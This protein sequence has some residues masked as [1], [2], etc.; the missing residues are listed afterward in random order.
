MSPNVIVPYTQNYAFSETPN[1]SDT[2][3]AVYLH[4]MEDSTFT[5]LTPRFVC[6][7]YVNDLLYT[8]YTGVHLVVHGMATDEYELP[9]RLPKTQQ[10]VVGTEQ[11]NTKHNRMFL[12]AAVQVVNVFR[13]NKYAWG[14]CIADNGRIYFAYTPIK[15]PD[16]TNPT[17]VGVDMLILRNWRIFYTLASIITASNALNQLTTAAGSGA[18]IMS[19]KTT[20]ATALAFYKRYGVDAYKIGAKAYTKMLDETKKDKPIAGLIHDAGA[21][22]FC[23]QLSTASLAGSI[24]AGGVEITMKHILK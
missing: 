23:G 17:T 21:K 12:G 2:G 14:T 10:L 20:F 15:T 5:Q 4:N 7:D 16:I 18:F 8:Y 3:W 19:D 22:V 6:K 24:I 9:F 13:S 11:I 1:P